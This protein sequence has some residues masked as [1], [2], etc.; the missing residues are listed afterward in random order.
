[1]PDFFE[2]M[3]VFKARV[4]TRAQ[5]DGGA[6]DDA[7]L[8][9][10]AKSAASDPTIITLDSTYL[11]AAEISN[12]SIDSYFTRM[13]S[14]SLKNYAEAS[15]VGVAFMSSHDTK[16]L[17]MGRSIRGVFTNSNG[18]GKSRV[19]SDFY[20]LNDLNL[21]GISTADFVRGVRAGIV[22]DVSIGFHGGEWICSICGLDM[23]DWYRDWPDGCMHYPGMEYS[24]FDKNGKETGVMQLCIATVENAGLSEV[25]AVYDGATPGAAIRKA[26]SM[27]EH[28][29]LPIEAARMIEARYQHRFKLTPEPVWAVGAIRTEAPPMTARR[30]QALDDSPEP[31][32]VIA[33]SEV[34]TDPVADASPSEARATDVEETPANVDPPAVTNEGENNVDPE[35]I[36]SVLAGANMENLPESPVEA[37]RAVIADRARLIP[38]ADDGRAYRADLIEE[39]V[40]EGIRAF[41]TDF[42]EEKRR[43]MFAK[44][45]LSDIKD[46]RDEWRAIGD[47][48]NPAGQVTRN[49]S[50]TEVDPEDED[51][52]GDGDDDSTEDRAKPVELTSRTR[53]VLPA[54]AY[55]G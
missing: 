35:E 55:A 15:N 26:L 12:N 11:W 41:G 25:S 48:R 51:T 13:G 10:L 52:E 45:D 5:G 21:N 29:K 42:K 7:V 44:L 4:L 3:G 50:E 37:L 33:T 34:S 31:I 54:A 40:V 14:S 53:R 8:L 30:D 16:K 17:P 2:A 36:R 47:L 19:V 24:E 1:M 6:A 49:G 39:A 22:S 46:T 18:N 43:A 9:D 38:L 20:T 32:G 27:A 28:G 23:M